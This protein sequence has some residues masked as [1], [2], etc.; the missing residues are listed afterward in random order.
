MTQLTL[1]STHQRSLKPLIEAA[2]IN[3]QRLLQAGIQRTEQRL[4]EFEAEHQITTETFICRYENDE[5]EET[6]GFVEWIG[7][8]RLLK[9]LREKVDVLRE[10]KF[11]D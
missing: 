10:I 2:L 5:F 4:R 8:Y 1:V 9:Q 11:A 3:E 6:L 7:E